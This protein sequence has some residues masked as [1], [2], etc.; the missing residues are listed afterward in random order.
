MTAGSERLHSL[1]AVRGFA[2]LLGVAFH[3]TLSFLPGPQLWPVRDAV[4][5]PELGAFFFVAHMFRMTVF[6]VIAGFFGRMLLERRGAAGFVAN[7]ATRI[8]VPLLAGWPIVFAAI[9]AVSIWAAI[10]AGGGHIPANAP[11]PPPLTAATFPL[12]HLWFLY[13][14]ILFYAAALALRG[15]V[16]LIDWRG[17]LRRGLEAPFRWIAGSGAAPLLLAVPQALAFWFA[18]TWRLWFGVTTPDTGFVPDAIAVTSYGAAF[19]VGWLAQRQADALLGAWRRWW[20][21]F[22]FGAIALSVVCLAMVGPE[23]VIEPAPHDRMRLIFG[24]LYAAAT[25]AWTL[26]LI[27]AAVRFFSSHNAARRWISDSSY[28]IYIVHLPV[29]M[30]LQVVVAPLP[31]PWEAKYA[32]VLI[33]AF[34]VL[35]ASYQL[36]VRY[37][38]I[39]RILNGRRTRPAPG[40]PAS[41]AAPAGDT[42]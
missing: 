40:A 33:A 1:D 15:A 19:A 39:G 2:L 10:Q 5:S 3:A 29:V 22:L 30:A 32:A 21:H 42:L 9:V 37:S 41:L 34:A 36:L 6:F 12:T 35:F 18:P 16:K 31:W 13:V 28:W 24:C 17:D 27:G 4:Q 26:G 20:L 23:P 7:R 8:G 14:L 11:P 38:F 25:W